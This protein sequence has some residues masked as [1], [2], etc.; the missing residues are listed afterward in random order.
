MQTKVIN[1]SSKGLA[2]W[3]S[4]SPLQY[5]RQGWGGGVKSYSLQRCHQP[6]P[7]GWERS[8][9]ES[10]ATQM[11]RTACTHFYTIKRMCQPYNCAPYAKRVHRATDST[12]VTLCGQYVKSLFQQLG[13]GN[14]RQ[15]GSG[16]CAKV[17]NSLHQPARSGTLAKSSAKQNSLILVEV[18]TLLEKGAITS[19]ENLSAHKSRCSLFPGRKAR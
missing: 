8:G 18:N 6:Y 7:R 10:E 12:A 2:A 9:S 1:C 13:S 16:L 3:F 15:V 19:V 17:S 11:T 4:E 5:S 14:N